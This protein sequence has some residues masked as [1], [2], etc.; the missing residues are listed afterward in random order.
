L[1]RALIAAQVLDG[2]RGSLALA[3]ETLARVGYAPRADRLCEALQDALRDIERAA[4]SRQPYLQEN[5]PPDEKAKGIH[6]TLR[7]RGQDLP[8]PFVTATESFGYAMFGAQVE[9]SSPEA[10]HSS[11]MSRYI[12]LPA[13]QQLLQDID[14]QTLLA[15][16]HSASRA[17]PRYFPTFLRL[18]HTILIPFVRWRFPDTSASLKQLLPE[19]L[20]FS[21]L[22]ADIRTDGDRVIVSP[23]NPAGYLRLWV[24]ILI[25]AIRTHGLRLLTSAGKTAL[26]FGKELLKLMKTVDQSPQD[27]EVVERQIDEM[28]GEMEEDVQEH[29]KS[30][31]T[32]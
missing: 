17:L 23:A 19:G 28:M 1:P 21:P 13:L 9:G 31:E 14:D 29:D 15:A 30:E 18:L 27:L 4:T 26:G 32:R 5:S 6:R 8:D 3:A 10:Q 2:G 11:A 16:Y 12:S 25:A 20:D 24:T 7:R 22:V